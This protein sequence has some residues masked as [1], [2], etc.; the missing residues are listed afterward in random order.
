M[1][2]CGLYCLSLRDVDYVIEMEKEKEEVLLTTMEVSRFGGNEVVC[3]NVGSVSENVKT[4]STRKLSNF[5]FQ[6][7][8]TLLY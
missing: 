5:N 7:I 4:E 1:V 8:K 6:W 2:D 3:A